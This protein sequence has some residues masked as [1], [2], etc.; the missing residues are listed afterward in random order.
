MSVICRETL[1]YTAYFCEENIWWAAR[2][3]VDAG[4]DPARMH[5]LLFTNPTQSVVMLNQRAAPPGAPIAW[6]YHV[7]LQAQFKD[8]VQIFDPDSRLDF[9]VPRA[10]YMQNTFP[11]QADLPQRYRAWISVIPALSYVRHFYSDRSHMRGQLPESEFPDYPIIQPAEGVAAIS[12]DAYRD[13]RRQLQ[14]GSEVFPLS[15]WYPG[16]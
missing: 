13:I 14:D 11:R 12:L 7:V 3:L 5:V 6:D 9:P 2:E 16:A 4:C 10:D 1:R 8:V 15:T